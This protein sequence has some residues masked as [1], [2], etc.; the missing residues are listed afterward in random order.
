MAAACALKAPIATCEIARDVL[1]STFTQLRGENIGSCCFPCTW[2]TALDAIVLYFQS[3][4]RFPSW[5]SPVRSRSPALYF[6]TLTCL[7]SNLLN[8][9]E[10]ELVNSPIQAAHS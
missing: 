2:L 4:V 9:E 6:N 3:T 7:I 5:T 10:S 1:H 8:N